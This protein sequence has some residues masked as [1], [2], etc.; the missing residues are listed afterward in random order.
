MNSAELSQA[1][2][3]WLA[4]CCRIG[5]LFWLPLPGPFR[6][7]PLLVR[8]ALVL[9]L[10]SALLAVQPTLPVVAEPAMGWLLL[11]ES[12][13]GLLFCLLLCAPAAA[14]LLVGK[15]LDMQL[16]LSAATVL[17]P[18]TQTHES[19]FSTLLLL[20]YV[21]LFWQ[22]GLHLDLLAILHFTLQLNPI[23]QL[24]LQDLPALLQYF[25]TAFQLGLIIGMPLMTVLF[26]ADVL[27]GMLSKSMPALNVY[28]VFL[29]AKIGIGLVAMASML[30][31]VQ[32]RL[33]Q[34]TQLPLHHL[35][36][37]L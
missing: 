29:P 11:K 31:F 21:T 13:V 28:F 3:V 30:P 10:G 23:G 6:Q 25:S 12:A 33:L 2:L 24:A 36:G 37:L 22:L 32:Q 8:N 35:Q 27:L 16:G 14:L 20:V 4:I 18:Q 19:V 7:V 17:N 15:I 34:L 1:G 9:V 5:W 26:I